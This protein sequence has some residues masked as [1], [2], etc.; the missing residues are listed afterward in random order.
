V[1]WLHK[2]FDFGYEVMERMRS[3]SSVSHEI[4]VSQSQYPAAQKN[5]RRRILLAGDG[6]K[7]TKLLPLHEDILHGGGERVLSKALWKQ[8]LCS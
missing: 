5:G 6:R 3:F 1:F 4:I 8:R 2:A 7:H